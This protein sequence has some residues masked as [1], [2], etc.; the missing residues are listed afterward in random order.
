[1]IR[2]TRINH[3]PLVLNSDLI[4]HIEC[5]P[6]TVVSLTN[7]Q[8]FM[9]LETDAEIISRVVNFRRKIFQAGFHSADGAAPGAL[10][11]ATL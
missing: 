9:V 5:T 7:G 1:M 4:E 11:E 6:D 2:L 10:Q 3:V 8:K